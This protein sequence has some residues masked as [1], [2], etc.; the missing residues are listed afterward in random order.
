M[1]ANALGSALQP[2]AFFF[3]LTHDPPGKRRVPD[4]MCSSKANLSFLCYFP[5][6]DLR[7]G[8]FPSWMI[9]SN[10]VLPWRIQGTAEL[11]NF[12]HP[13]FLFH[14]SFHPHWYPQIP[15]TLLPQG[16]G[17]GCSLCLRCSLPIIHF[18]MSFWLLLNIIPP[19]KPFL[20]SLSKML[21]HLTS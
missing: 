13:F 11:M 9:N 19:R 7:C 16:L 14:S 15:E 2:G 6:S 10:G 3:I 20:T 4:T 18:L 1:Q 8:I 17:T 21:N 5:N 12:S